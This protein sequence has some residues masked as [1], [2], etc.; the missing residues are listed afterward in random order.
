MKVWRKTNISASL[1][2]DNRNNLVAGEGKL[3]SAHVGSF[4]L[5][6]EDLQTRFARR[7]EQLGLRQVGDPLS[8]VP[9]NGSSDNVPPA[10]RGILETRRESVP[11]ESPKG[12]KA[13]LYA[14]CYT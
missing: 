2:Q 9:L 13:S 3:Q 14:A 12:M 8:R 4:F 1:P 11:L 7:R 5:L 6:F 10:A